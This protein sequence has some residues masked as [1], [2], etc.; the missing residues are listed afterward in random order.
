[1]L[2]L[3]SPYT[4]QLASVLFSYF[5]LLRYL[6]GH[7]RSALASYITFL[8]IALFTHSSSMLVFAAFSVVLFVFL[9][10]G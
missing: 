3:T 6:D 2:Q 4:L 9:I 8:S 1:M 7:R 10:S 5:G